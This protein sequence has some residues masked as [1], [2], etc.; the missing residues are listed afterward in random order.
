MALLLQGKKNKKLF[1]IP[2][3]APLTSVILAT[4]I[5]YITRADKKGVQIVSI[6]QNNY[7]PFY[8]P[9]LLQTANHLQL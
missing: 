5:V 2:A 1:W 4:L 3:I 8:D 6:L 9:M 7:S